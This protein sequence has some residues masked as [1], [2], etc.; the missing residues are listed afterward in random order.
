MCLSSLLLSCDGAVA[1]ST[2]GGVGLASAQN[3]AVF[4]EEAVGLHAVESDSCSFAF[5]LAEDNSSVSIVY[6]DHVVGTDADVGVVSAGT[7]VQTNVVAAAANG[8]IQV[9]VAPT[10][11]HTNAVVAGT[12]V[13]AEVIGSQATILGDVVVAGAAVGSESVAAPAAVL[14]DGV[15]T[16][17]AVG[18]CSV[19]A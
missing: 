4:A 8:V 16:G 6:G 2:P 12:A 15:V 5:A 10:A 9:V 13:G 11:V 17:A 1:C 19:G 3:L 14:S 18:S 7:T